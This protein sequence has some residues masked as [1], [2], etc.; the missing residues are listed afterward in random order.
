MGGKQSS[1]AAGGDAKAFIERTV[2]EHAVV[3][4]S[5]STCPYCVRVK[6]LFGDVRANIFLV[7]LNKRDDMSVLQDELNRITGARTVICFVCRACVEC[8][9]YV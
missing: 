1:S 3:V 8:C 6:K 9:T 7:E 5:K 4:F 2:S